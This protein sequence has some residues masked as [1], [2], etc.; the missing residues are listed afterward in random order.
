MIRAVS[1]TRQ[2]VSHLTQ[3]SPPTTANTAIIRRFN[4]TVRRVYFIPTIIAVIFIALLLNYLQDNKGN[5]T[6]Y[7]DKSGEFKRQ[8]SQF[9]NFITDKS[10]AEFPPEKDRYH[11]YVSYACPWGE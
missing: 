1:R 3:S 8:Q 6:K 10:D 2:L 11:L 9:R 5:I 7:A 4:M